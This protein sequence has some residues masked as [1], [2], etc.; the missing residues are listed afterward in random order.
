MPAFANKT[1]KDCWGRRAPRNV[2]G[3]R[4]ILWPDSF[5]N[6]F[7]RQTL[8]AAVE[9]LEDAGFRIV[10]PRASLCCGRPLYDF[11]MLDTA[12]GLLRQILDTLAPE[13][14][15]GTPIV[16]LEPSCVAVFRD[17]LRGLFPM[18]ENDRRLG[19]KVFTLDEFLEKK[20]LDYRLPGLKRKAL[21]HGHCHQTHATTPRVVALA[22]GVGVLIGFGL[23]CAL[24]HATRSTTRNRAWHPSGCSGQYQRPSK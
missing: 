22:M 13:I 21:V 17:E 19:D 5:N 20:A 15:V 7:H 12:K 14:E 3:E 4:V 8:K 10:V 6:H 18:E 9:V 16:G 23:T 11:G 2:G 24:G 1:F